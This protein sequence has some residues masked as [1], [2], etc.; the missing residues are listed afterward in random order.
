MY[1]VNNN[2]YNYK[3]SKLDFIL[4]KGIFLDLGHHNLSDTVHENE[5]RKAGT[6]PKFLFARSNYFL[7]TSYTPSSVGGK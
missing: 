5:V 2:Y 7:Q 4:K 3:I 6:F 1:I